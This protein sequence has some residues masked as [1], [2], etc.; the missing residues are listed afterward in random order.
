MCV[1]FLALVWCNNN[2]LVHIFFSLARLAQ[3]LSAWR[4]TVFREK[5]ILIFSRSLPSNLKKNNEN[6]WNKKLLWCDLAYENPVSEGILARNN[7]NVFISISGI[8]SLNLLIKF[9]KGKKVKWSLLDSGS[10]IQV[11]ITDLWKQMSSNNMN[12]ERVG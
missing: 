1:H 7:W 10:Y 3:I 12:T 2:L 5:N 9:T 8:F 6:P 4:K 11:Q